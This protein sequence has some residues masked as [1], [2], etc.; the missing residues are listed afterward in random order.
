MC[1][2][3][4]ILPQVALVRINI[5]FGYVHGHSITEWT[6]ITALASRQEVPTASCGRPTPGFTRGR[7]EAP[8]SA[9]AAGSGL[10]LKFQTSYP[11]IG[12]WN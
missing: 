7:A 3:P 8:N 12:G 11:K 2:T 9:A 6:G 5:N 4:E 10:D 1:L